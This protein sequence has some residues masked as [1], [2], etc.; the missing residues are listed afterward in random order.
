MTKGKKLFNVYR[1]VKYDYCGMG[2]DSERTEMVGKTWAVSDK[3]AACNVAYRNG[4][5]TFDIIPLWG[6]GARTVFYHAEE[7]VKQ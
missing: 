6:D 7:A 3:K 4:E 2:V 5:K 1:T